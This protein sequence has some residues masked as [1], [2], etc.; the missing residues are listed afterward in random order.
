[1]RGGQDALQLMCDFRPNTF[2]I[3]L[4]DEEFLAGETGALFLFV[5]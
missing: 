2:R 5:V 4:Q 3:T 1:M